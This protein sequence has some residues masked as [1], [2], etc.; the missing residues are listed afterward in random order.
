MIFLALYSFKLLKYSLKFLFN[1]SK[2]SMFIRL[3][4][5]SKKCPTVYG[6]MVAMEFPLCNLKS[7]SMF[8]LKLFSSTVLSFWFESTN[9]QQ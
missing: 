1:L 4:V 9:L 6:D 3:I 5:I 8:L 2:I 7:G